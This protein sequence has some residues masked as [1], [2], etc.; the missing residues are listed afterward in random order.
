M[1]KF[2][3]LGILFSI[4][5]FLFSFSVSA[6]DKT[7]LIYF[8]GDGC[9]H[10]AKESKFLETISEKY[11]EL[12]ITKYEVW[13]NAQ[14]QKLFAETARNLGITRLGVPLTIIG[15]KYFIGYQDDQTTG[16]AIEEQI[17]SILGE[18][19]S[20]GTEGKIKIPFLGEVDPAKISL[21][22]L[23]IALGALD[24]F[25][26]CAMWILLFLIAL[27]ISIHSRKKLLLI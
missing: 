10:C 22:I 18:K 25:N 7:E 3:F 8:W 11:P 19:P 2:Y 13:Y 20:S 4:F 5:Y 9:P 16:K 26:P 24:G 17:I 12:K 27:L 21:P 15:D 6:Q 1:K 23:T 14:N